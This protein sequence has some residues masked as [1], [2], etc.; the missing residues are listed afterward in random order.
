MSVF[1]HAH[2]C[3]DTRRGTRREPYG[4]TR[5]S[6]QKTHAY[7]RVR[8]ETEISLAARMAVILQGVV[9]KSSSQ[10]RRMMRFHSAGRKTIF[11]SASCFSPVHRG[12]PKG[13]VACRGT[14]L[15]SWGCW[16]WSDAHI[17]KGDGYA[18][19]LGVSRHTHLVRSQSKPS[20]R[21][22]YFCELFWPL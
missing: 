22:E 7:P 14:M 5:S 20:G 16:G 21:L 1:A 13:R 17:W 9:E 10:C 19:Q 12:G 15:M 18:R 3:L 8:A 11:K 6:G 4:N 2:A